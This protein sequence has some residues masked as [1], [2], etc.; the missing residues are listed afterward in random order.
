MKSG[1]RIWLTG[2]LRATSKVYNNEISTYESLITYAEKETNGPKIDLLEVFAGSANLT[3]RAPLHGLSALEPVDKT[4]NLDLKEY[5]DQQALWKIIHKFKPLAVVV[6]WPC[7]F[8]SIFNENMNYAHRM[9]ELEELRESDRPLVRL[10]ADLMKYQHSKGRIFVGEI[11]LH[12]RIWDEAEVQQ[13]MDLPGTLSTKCDAGAYG[14][15]SH[16]GF[17]VI[18]T[19]RWITNSEDVAEELQRRLTS[20]QKFYTK[21][22][23]GVDTTASG[24]YCDGLADAILR[25]IAK[26]AKRRD[27]SRF[28]KSNK[29]YYTHPSTDEDRWQEV[30]NE[31]EKRFIN[32]HTRSRFWCIPAILSTRRFLI[33]SHGNWNEFKPLG[34]QRQG[35][36]P[37][38]L[39][40][41]TEALSCCSTTTRSW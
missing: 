27:P 38:T 25:G 20:E 1:T 26:A 14:A 35:D 11:P 34:H 22:I 12:S 23:Q 13:V 16:D 32:T 31:L 33:W 5:K 10:G 6:A 9:H 41:H 29:I 40:T 18:K 28:I 19:H 39:P 7:R 37:P 36:F 8:W 17:P 15:E 4:I 21:P 30:M 2:H 3:F 24:C